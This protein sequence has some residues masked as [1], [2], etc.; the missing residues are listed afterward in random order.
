MWGGGNSR[1][2]SATMTT[3]KRRYMPKTI[4]LIFD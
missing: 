2:I 3:T 4:K 1:K